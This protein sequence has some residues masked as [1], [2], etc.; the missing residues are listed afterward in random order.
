MEY[1]T[2]NR[3]R[4]HSVSGIVNIPYGTRIDCENG[5]LSIDGQ[6]LCGDQSQN[7][8]DFFAR[9]DD[10]NGLDRGKLT[11][12]IIK[13]MAVRDK[14]YQKRWNKVWGDAICR[15]YKRSEH[16]E[17]WL[18]NYDFFNAEIADLKYIAKLVG[19]KF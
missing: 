4:F 3:A 19:A 17:H 13:R 9:N 6:P 12:S 11:R 16:E 5:I 1:I 14:A 15:K 10:G 2:I 7:A 18:W 8:Y